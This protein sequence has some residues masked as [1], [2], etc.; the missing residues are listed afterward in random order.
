[1]MPAMASISVEPGSKPIP[2]REIFSVSRLNREARNLLERGFGSL[3]L[4]GEVSNLSRPASGHWYF[5]L[6]DDAAQVRC[7]MFRSRNQLVRLPVLDGAKVVAR[8]RVS[9]Y[10]ARGE[11]Q[12][13][14]EHL[15]E[16]GEGLLRRRIEELKRRLADEGLFDP[17]HRK[18]LPALPRRVGVITTPTGA[19]I[20]DIL[21]VLRRRFPPVPVLI[22]PVAVQGMFAAGEIIDALRLAARRADCDVL[23]LA[24]GGGSLEDL[25]SFNDE[26]VARAVHACPIPVVSGIGHETDFTIVDFVADERAPTPSGAAERVVPDRAEWLRSF[27]AVQRRG[28]YAVRRRLQELT[29]ALGFR[30]RSLAR[31]H[32]GARLRQHAQRLDE[33][34]TRLRRAV[35]TTLARQQTRAAQAGALLQRASPALRLRALGLRHAVAHRALAAAGRR[36]LSAARRRFESAL[37]TLH[38]TGP[39]ATLER[40]Y[41]IVMTGAGRAL[42][43]AAETSPGASLDVRLWRGSLSA[44]VTATTPAPPAGAEPRDPA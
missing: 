37:R 18:P 15:E 35:R 24:R 20:R 29:T 1:M 21:H 4:E 10:E 41:A 14:V 34:D 13:V 12:V 11:F 16:A 22:Y 28:I 33:L 38:A 9:L 27:A 30:S 17:A 31:A 19:A 36:N 25:Q 44:T 32:P 2:E 7:C 23:I 39:Q 3:W 6:K 8:G 43:D 26:A 40:G 42:R 5:S